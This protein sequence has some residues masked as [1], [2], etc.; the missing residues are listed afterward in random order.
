V[1]EI[2]SNRIGALFTI[3]LAVCMAFVYPAH[4]V[5]D[6]SGLFDHHGH[7]HHDHHDHS[8]DHQHGDDELCALCLSLSSIEISES[9]Q[10]VH[11]VA[12]EPFFQNTLFS[13]CRNSLNLSDARAPPAGLLI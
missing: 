10:L 3:A 4:V 2:T 6:H 13:E 9:V 12:D 5:I 1:I 7:A 11:I 8:E